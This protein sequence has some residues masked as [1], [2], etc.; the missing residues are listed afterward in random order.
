MKS[1]KTLNVE[2]TLVSA[3]SLSRILVNLLLQ[4]EVLANVKHLK[5]ITFSVAVLLGGCASS[6]GHAN[7]V[8]D[9]SVGELIVLHDKQSSYSYGDN[10]FGSAKVFL[11]FEQLYKTKIINQSKSVRSDFFWA[12]M[13]HLRFD[14]DYMGQFQSIAYDDLGTDFIDRLQNYVDKESELKHSKDKLFLSN[15]VLTGLKQL[16]NI[17]AGL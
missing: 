12:A 16:K 11:R 6:S 1:F 8:L 10:P 17:K 9:T 14:G 15:Q 5:K 7:E 4:V 13:W 2:Q 3:V